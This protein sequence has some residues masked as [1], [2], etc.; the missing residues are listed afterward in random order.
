MSSVQHTLTGIFCEFSFS[1]IP[2][3][4]TSVSFFAFFLRLISSV[5]LNL[6][7]RNRIEFSIFLCVFCK[8]FVPLSDSCVTSTNFV[9]VPTRDLCLCRNTRGSQVSSVHHTLTQIF[10]CEF[11]ISFVLYLVTSVSFFTLL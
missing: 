11:S 7:C 2:Y 8:T 10:F 5:I 6:L 9:P 3:P 1:F 4:E